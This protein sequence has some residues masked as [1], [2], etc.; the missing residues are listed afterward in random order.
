MVLEIQPKGNPKLFSVEWAAGTLSALLSV[1]A[2]CLALASP[3]A[4]AAQDTVSVDNL[5]ALAATIE[6]ETKRKEL[7]ARIRALISAQKSLAAKMTERVLAQP[8]T[9]CLI[10][11]FGDSSVDL[12][13]RIWINDPA[14]GVSNVKSAV[15]L[16]VWDLFHEHGIEIPFPQRDLHIKSP[17]ALR[18]MTSAQT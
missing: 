11:G 3:V 9:V 14:N 13:I 8:K 18:V 16:N 12:E 5:E 6:D 4:V 7:V 2:V 10:S 1:I 17:E 15:L